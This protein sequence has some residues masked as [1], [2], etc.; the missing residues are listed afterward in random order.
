[1][2]ASISEH[3]LGKKWLWLGEGRCMKI[4][5][6]MLKSL[7]MVYS[8]VNLKTHFNKNYSNDTGGWF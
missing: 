2:E 3:E 5:T 4:Y 1:M 8:H 7:C 6:D